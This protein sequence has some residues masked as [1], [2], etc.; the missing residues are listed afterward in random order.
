MSSVD[1]IAIIGGGPCGLFGLYHANMRQVS[2]RLFD[3]MPEL[4]GQVTSLYPDKEI[5]DIGGM[6]RV[7]GRELIARLGEQ[8]LKDGQSLCLGEQVLSLER[9]EEVFRLGTTMGEHLARTVVIAAGLGAFRPR[10]LGVPGE[11]EFCGRGV[12]YHVADIQRFVGQRVL[13]VGG[14]DSALDWAN[15]LAPLAE[16]RLVHNLPKWQAHEESVV[17]MQNSGVRY[18]Q[19]WELR[20]IEGEGR[21]QAA[22]IGPVGADSQERIAVDEILICIGFSTDLGPIKNWGLSIRGGQIEVD[23]GMRTGVDGVFAAGDIVT[24]SG[25]QRLIALGFGEVGLAV[26]SAVRHLHPQQRLITK[27]SS[28]RGF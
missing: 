5:F 10:Q 7:K 22:V 4:G 25:K 19:P 2:A 17:R 13:I 27:H 3:S 9:E 8:C 16:V 6:P 21:V 26:D 14:G 20:E 12:A 15:T 23:W 28:D 11:A 1:D 24:Y 18:G